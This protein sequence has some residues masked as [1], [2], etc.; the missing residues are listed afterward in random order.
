MTETQAPYGNNAA[1][2]TTEKEM[3]YIME[4]GDEMRLTMSMVKKYLVQGRSEF[5]TDSEILYFMHEC[6]ARKLN[7]FLRQCWLIKYSQKDNAQIIESIQNKRNK[8][9]KAEDCKGW[10]KGLILKDADGNTKRSKGLLLDGETLLG[11][12]F[13][14][15]PEG[16]ETPYELEINLEGYIKKK[17]DGNLTAFWSKE[18]QPSQIM[19]VAE[20]QGLSALWGDTIGNTYIPEELPSIDMFQGGEGTYEEKVDTSAFDKLVKDVKEKKELEAFIKATAKGNNMAMEA[21]KAQSVGHFKNFMKAFNTYLKKQAEVAETAK[22]PEKMV[23]NSEEEKNWWET[24]KHWKFLGGEKFISAIKNRAEDLK[25][26]D[27]KI[28]KAVYDKFLSKNKKEDWPFAKKEEKHKPQ[29]GGNPG[30]TA[31][32]SEDFEA[33]KSSSSDDPKKEAGEPSPEE[34]EL[35]QAKSEL[36]ELKKGNPG[37]VERAAYNLK[38]SVSPMTLDGVTS[39]IEETLSQR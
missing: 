25:A 4:N 22:E 24:E 36:S 12:F 37:M 11:A 6:K 17:Q 21:V 32:N 14:A 20:S 15:T 31:R 19:K 39:L 8:A 1:P 38:M 3:T 34:D 9:R 23:G 26:T 7:P 10:T 33:P 18:K 16:W 27:K 29:L 30:Y 5:V 13:E 28:Q 2:A 35:T